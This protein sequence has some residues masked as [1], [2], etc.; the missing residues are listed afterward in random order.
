MNA[1][2]KDLQYG[3]RMLYKNRGFTAVAL[4]ALALGIGANTAIFSVVNSVLLRPLPYRDPQRLIMVWENHQQ[5]GGAEHEWTA[6]ADFRDFRDQAQSFEHVAAL[7]GWGPTLTGQDQPEDLQGAAVSHDTFAM[8]GVEPALGRSFRPDEDQAGAERVA[9]LSHNLWQRRFGS[10]PAIVGKNLTLGGESYTVIGVMPRG[11][12]FPILKDTEIW[13]PITPAL[14]AI[15]GCGRGCVILR[16][17]AKLNPGVT[18]EA[19]R[20]EMTAL[21]SRLAEQYP[22]SN[23]AVGAALVP[24]H[25]QL[26]GDVRPAMLVLLGAVGL[27]L[28][29]ACANVANLLLARA[30]AREKEVAI[31]A[32]LGASRARL[33]RQHLT[34]SLVLAMTGGAVGLLLAF[35]IVDLLVSFAPKGT[36]RLDEIAIDPIVLAFT[37]GVALLTGLVFGLA[38]ALLS[39]RTN[40]NSA[41]KEGGRD[42]SASSRGA[43]VRSALVV[44]EVALALMLLVGAA[45]LI[46]S[47]VNLQRV[48]PGFNPKDVVRV[49]VALPRTR[50]PERNQSATF[51]KQ[52]LD[53]IAALPGVQSAGA[54]SNLPLSG[55]GTDSDFGIE[56]RAPAEPGQNPV[57]WY[58][59]VTPGYFRAM[60]IRLLRGR[61]FSEADNA[62]APKTVL[63]S[64]TMARRYFPDED[65]LGKR[66]VFG[67]GSDPREIVGVISDV[68]F[69][70]LN[71]DARPSMYFPHAQN[72]AGGM[73]LVVRTQGDLLTLA[74]AIRGQVSALDRDLAVS[75]VM[76]MEQLVGV[77]LAEPRF[78][79]LLL[80]AFA[81]VAMLLSA[82]GVYGV[83]SYSVTQRSHEIGVRM[84]LGAQMSDV[85]KLVVGQGMTLVLGGVGLGLIAAFAL[86][87]VMES[88]LFGVSATDF[89]TFAA[90]SVVLA[91]VALAACFIPARRAIRVDPMVAL[92]YE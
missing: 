43:R 27:V 63:I 88:L 66:L 56:G 47:F 41:L 5:R 78:T 42:T 80:G 76:T 20:A 22:E 61:V 21:T 55:G 72:P 37:C 18:L 12:S 50:Y 46:K 36:P 87:R 26:V 67:G 83:V 10:D 92:R 34:E 19:A 45:L 25:E 68:K 14:A 1:L 24:L 51:Y 32:A 15:P 2:L 8:L 54:V 62:D 23:K 81:A 3:V 74:A 86:S 49:D 28:L 13:R 30:A 69:F 71:L 9:V 65:P 79:L 73:S 53:R 84:A 38:P 33:I 48:A 39:S 7:V 70:G 90:T 40:F 60:G 57:A 59:S 58:S 44:S 35:W 89:T 91:G 77:S 82:I 52:L 16:V 29:I 85:L 6:P 11:F 31:R 4:L 75:N 64:E 17:I